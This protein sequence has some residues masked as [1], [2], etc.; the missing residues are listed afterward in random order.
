MSVSAFAYGVVAAAG[1]APLSALVTARSST[2]TKAGTTATAGYQIKNDG[3]ASITDAFGGY[4]NISG[5]WETAGR[6]PSLY[7]VYFH[8][9]SGTLSG[10]PTEDTWLN[11]GTTYACIVSQATVGTKT[12]TFTVEIRNAA[13]TASLSG[14]VSIT[15][16]AT[17]S[18]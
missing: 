15:L 18:S 17:R 10:G 3:N 7:E 16:T 6:S 13:T 12:C 11:C 4:G 1:S 5:E 9:T 14:P 2:V 8:V